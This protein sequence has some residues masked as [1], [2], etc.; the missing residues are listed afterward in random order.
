MG[1]RVLLIDEYKGERIFDNMLAS[2]IDCKEVNARV[3][4]VTASQPV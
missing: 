1:V 3:E 2:I 4:S